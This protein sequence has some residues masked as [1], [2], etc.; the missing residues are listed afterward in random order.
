MS[1]YEQNY[2]LE[3]FSERM[4]CESTPGNVLRV[5]HGVLFSRDNPTNTKSI[6]SRFPYTNLI[7]LRFGN[8]LVRH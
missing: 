6:P 7:P 4:A 2:H 8:A 1:E 3:E 5:R